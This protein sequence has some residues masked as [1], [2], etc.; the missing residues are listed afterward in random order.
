MGK[1]LDG[2]EL[3]TGLRQ[4]AD[5]KYVARFKARSGKR[6]EKAFDKLTEAKRWL[7]EQRYL[8]EH[9][10]LLFAQSMTLDTWYK[11]W[12]ETK[13]PTVRD[14]TLNIYK[15]RYK[16]D[17]KPS[18]GNMLLSDIKPLHCQMVLN[19]MEKSQKTQEITK[20]IMQQLFDSAVDNELLERSP[21]TRIVKVHKTE[22]EERRVFTADE[23]ER[24]VDYLNSSDYK[25]KNAYLFI[26]ETGL[27]IGEVK[28][29]MWGDLT[30]TT[31][32]VRRNMVSLNNEDVIHE[33]KTASGY[34]TVPL[35][36]KARAII[37][38]IKR[39]P[40]VGRYVFTI[41]SDS[42]N[43]CL[44]WIC[45]KLGIEP[46]TVHGLRHSF[47]TRCIERNMNPKTLQKILGH[48]T[49]N[50]TMDLYVHVTEETLVSEMLKMERG[51]RVAK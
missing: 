11:Y 45:D 35:T 29:L 1:G 14:T 41:D 8:D 22:K 20:V 28:G 6:P 42:I 48:K 36:M 17:V 49:L 7:N 47:A 4:R 34:R 33:P 51:G 9:S 19:Q 24:F 2:K 30:D 31:L 16:F 39:Q 37:R 50:M 3:G 18:L 10:N 43:T 32:T 21:I 5:G 44:K 40:I 15:R 46:I 25:Y 12:L 13:A 23:Q 38:E 26:L 27:R